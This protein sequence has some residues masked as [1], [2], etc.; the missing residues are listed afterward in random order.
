MAPQ[1][2][3]DCHHRYAEDCRQLALRR[4]SL[5]SRG[6]IDR[7]DRLRG[8]PLASSHLETEPLGRLADRRG[9]NTEPVRNRRQRKPLIEKA[10]E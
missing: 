10:C 9:I 8:V 5:D 7:V 1:V 2:P 3:L 6:Q 4:T